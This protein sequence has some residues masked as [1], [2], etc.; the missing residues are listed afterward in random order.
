MHTAS[1]YEDFVTGVLNEF[2]GVDAQR[3]TWHEGR[4]TRRQIQVDASFRLKTI[5]GASILCVVECKHYRN[6]VS[7]DDIEEFHSKLDDLGA[8]KGIMITTVGYQ[9]GARKAAIGRGIALALLTKESQPGE[10]QYIVNSI[11]PVTDRPEIPDVLQGNV[12]GVISDF[13]PGLRFNGFG[14]LLGMLLIDAQ[15]NPHPNGAA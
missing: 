15:A 13:E 8:H 7:V 14:Q 5:G 10:I 2:F 4:V 6:K 9:A 1:D 12:C 11:A 3:A